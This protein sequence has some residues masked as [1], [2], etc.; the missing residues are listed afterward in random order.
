MSR[1]LVSCFQW[2]SA[3]LSWYHFLSLHSFLTQQSP[4]TTMTSF[5]TSLLPEKLTDPQL[6]RIFPTFYGTREFIIAFTR[7]RHMSLSWSRSIQSMPPHHTSQ[8]FILI[9]SSHLRLGLP[10][11]FLLQVSPPNPAGLCTFPLPSPYVLHALPIS[12]LL[13]LSPNNVCWG[14]QS[15]KFLVMQSSP[16]PCYFVPV[17]HKYPPQYPILED[18]QPW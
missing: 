17:R 12:N 1:V 13:I 7:A 5:H 14:V 16:F 18:S 6:V 8:I 4:S 11:G 10:S 3:L 15:I 9:L 2:H